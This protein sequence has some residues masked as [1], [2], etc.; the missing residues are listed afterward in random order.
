MIFKSSTVALIV[1]SVLAFSANASDAEIAGQQPSVGN[2]AQ[3][4]E[5]I[6]SDVKSAYVKKNE[7]MGV[8]LIRLS[9]KSA[10]DAS[11]SYLGDDRSSIVA[12]VEQQQDAIIKTI[13]S[14]DNSAV[15]TRKARLTENVLYVQMNHSV[16]QQLTDHFDVVAVELLSEE[17]N[18]SSDDEFKRFPFLNVKDV[19]DSITVAIVGNGI[20]Y[21]HKSLG[22]HG[23]YDMAWANRSNAWDGFPTDTVIGG[24]DFSAGGEGYHFIDYNPIE[25]AEDENVKSGAIP[26]GTAV[27]AQ[28]LAQAPDAKI[29]S[30]KTWD[31]SSA[32]FFPVL[33]V[34]IDPNQDGDISD[35]PEVI[36]LNAYGNGA[37]YVEDD[38]NG[39][40]PTR[41]INLVRRL[42]AS[43]A[44][45]VVGAGQTYFNSYFNLAWRG[46]VPEALT[47]GSVNINEDSIVL[48][49]FTPAGPTRGTHQLKPEVVAPAENVTAP[50][51]GSSDATADFAAHSTYAAAYAAGAVAKIL[52]SYPE[53]SPLEAKA[54]VAN[55]A[56]AEG[57]QGSSTYNEEL[58]RN[59]TNVAEVPFMGSGLVDGDTAVTASAV[60]WETA[61]YQPGLAFGF[62]EA[63]SSATLS[64]D[65]TIRNL[66]DKVQTYSV[67]TLTNGDKANNG[68]V[69]FIYPETINVPANHSV[70]FNVSMTLDA[71]KLTEKGMSS[72]EDFTIANFTEENINGY[73][74]FTNSDAASAQLKM[75]WQ[76]FPKN[77]ETLVKSNQTNSWQM[78]YEAFDWQDQLWAANA[79]SYTDTLDLT[80]EGNA[81]K[82]IYTIPRMRSVDTIT[83]SKA[84]GQG[85]MIKNLG[86]SVNT[87][88]SCEAGSKLSVAVQMFDKFDIPMAEHFDKAGHLLTYFSI[89]TQ[90]YVDRMNGDAQQID[91]DQ[92]RTDNDILAYVE[93]LIDNDGKPQ[94]EYIDYSQEYEWWN[95]RKRF[96]KS[97]LGADVSLGDDTVVA[98]I[99]IDEL[100]HGDIQS[101]DNWNENLGWQFATDR[102][103][104]ADIHEDMI[105]YNPVIMGRSFTEIIDHT[106]EY[107]YPEWTYTNCDPNGVD[108][109]GNPFPEDYCIEEAKT[110]VAFHT[111]ITKL[112]DDENAELTWSNKVDLASGES[113]RVSVTTVDDCNPNLIWFGTRPPLHE[114]C[115][116]SVMIFELGT[117]NTGFSGTEYGADIGVKAG[118]GFS[119]YEN[120][121]NG[122][123][124]GKLARHAVRFFNEDE[125]QGPIYLVN[126][127]PGTPFSVATDGTI[128][129]ANSSALDYEKIKSYTLKVQADYGNRDTQIVD[130]VIK[131]NNRNDVAPNVVKALRTISSSVGN[132]INTSVADAF[133]DAEG[134]G[135]TFSANNL[136][137]G[138]VID[139]AGLISGVLTQTGNY[140]ATVVATDGIN[141]TNVQMSF[142]VTGSTDTAPVDNTPIENT[143]VETLPVENTPTDDVKKSSNSGGSTSAFFILLAGMSFINRRVFK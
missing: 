88:M 136:P 115:P 66:T 129:V 56:V 86:A 63:S 73:L 62:V 122:S 39:S 10:M 83:E 68:A 107:N 71:S 87:D 141:S 25:D 85:H 77:A 131:I 53:L 47:V 137:Q 140:E 55:T 116:P 120:A 44:L 23:N 80:N 14:L 29:L 69:S 127:L 114:A 17:P 64:R 6:T 92:N 111:G 82:T 104:R 5:N 108:W 12:K 96:V 93:V 113:A 117:D 97:S 139:R 128:S 43:G 79:N 133:S 59:I 49:E 34:I 72:T 50:L 124:I 26:S 134:D 57:I 102:D 52:A 100:Y 38:T 125:H 19:G 7:E 32:Y 16:A 48:S 20:D 40:S 126:A 28:I 75:P 2:T 22:G 61:S 30:Y 121:E 81:S 76:V 105:R 98:N 21:T 15:L 101:V 45:V 60:V 33:D 70:V 95:P 74:V 54:L 18:Y 135:I 35:R 8:Y 132:Q 58:E 65:I 46:A 9:E 103:A 41:E 24:L 110:F 99:C 138:I 4:E 11:Y 1:S 143:P 118:Q 130:V 67:T 3:G 106:G 90:E 112:S 109:M 94:V 89:F 78:P 37:F 27:A 123:V 36:V 84:G 91:M 51:A 13:R 119:T 142:N 42:S 31:W